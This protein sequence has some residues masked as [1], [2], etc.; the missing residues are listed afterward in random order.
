[1]VARQT[2]FLFAVDAFTNLVDY[3]FHLY[4]G[5][6]L[7][8]G[9]FA[10]V[11]TVN[12]ALLIIVAAFG[13]MQPVV[14]RHV[15]EAEEKQRR[16]LST[17]GG[18]GSAVAASDALPS[19]VF[20]QH[21]FRGS[22]MLGVPLTGAVWFG[23]GT[24]A[25]WLNVPSWA[26]GLSASM[27]LLTLLRPVVAGM[28]QGQQRFVAFGLTRTVH[29]VCRLGSSWLLIILGAGIVGALAAFPIGSFLA[30]LAGLGFL[31]LVVWRPGPRLP[32]H[33]LRQGLRLAVGAF[34][35]YAAYMFLLN[36][37]L[38][39]V[40]RSFA[41]ETAGGYATLVVL[42]RI[43]ALLPGAVMVIMYPR[44]VAAVTE[45]QLPDR[46]LWAVAT[47]VLVSNLVFT[48]LYAAFGQQIVDLAFG[49]GYAAVGSLLGWMGVAMLG[50]SLGAVWLNLYL[51]TR[52]APFVLLLL[53]T[54]VAQNL[55]FS[56]CHTTLA[57]VVTIFAVVGWILAGGG[58]FI[59]R[60]WLRPRLIAQVEP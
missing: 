32:P 55:L 5:R 42:R 19:R 4:L 9:E 3:A 56:I 54:A 17:D 25:Q 30:L 23:R 18:E 12:S 8:P 24:L 57:Q 16:T 27:V 58:L 6:A 59:Y 51:A 44:V 50:Y 34:V 26:V 41:P 2:I 28:L 20:F 15:A 11:E 14:A 60:L 1:M 38:V 22:A 37:D 7:L 33:L 48:G 53:L 35:A 45:G 13:V 21:Y 29:A 52:P 47:V 49:S 31:G 39:W 43:L 46:I 10:V 40:N 36:S